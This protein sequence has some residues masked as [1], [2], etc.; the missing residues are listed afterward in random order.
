VK[1]TDKF[2]IGIVA[3]IIL[4]VVVALGVALNR[5]KPTFQADDTPE[6]VAHNYLLAIQQEDYERA[7]GYLSPGLT[8]Y[9]DSV[10]AFVRNV[11]DNRWQF[12]GDAETSL[13]IK[14]TAIT[15]QLAV[16]EVQASRFYRG[17]LF[18]SGQSTSEFEM[19][20]QQQDT[21][22]KIIDSTDYFAS[23]WVYD[24]GCR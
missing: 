8:G 1:S 22:W 9:P 5:P 24:D 23:C 6:G 2:L 15:R 11:R 7:Y 12:G 20:L 10:E 17:S 13:K 16:V 4:L 14:S 19:Q 21:G 3:G 18:D